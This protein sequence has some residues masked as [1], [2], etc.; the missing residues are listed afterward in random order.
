VVVG[1]RVVVV[2]RCRAEVGGG[3]PPGDVDGVVAAAGID[4]G[5]CVEDDPRVDVVTWCVRSGC[6]VVVPALGQHVVVEAVECTPV[7]LAAWPELPQAASSASAL[8]SPQR[9]VSPRRVRP[10]I[11]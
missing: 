10:F 9:L 7:R 8:A 4:V 5:E 11:V 3:P 1:G 2:E 6:T